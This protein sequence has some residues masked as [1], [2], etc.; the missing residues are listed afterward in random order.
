MKQ[1]EA[2]Y[3]IHELFVAI[4]KT[5]DFVSTAI[6][7]YVAW[8][9]GGEL[10]LQAVLTTILGIIESLLIDKVINIIGFE[11]GKAEIKT[12]LKEDDDLKKYL[13]DMGNV[14]ANGIITAIHGVNHHF[15]FPVCYI[16]T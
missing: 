13:R 4:K 10:T 6:K 9:S 11:Q 2:E 12:F 14:V 5:Y 7:L 1:I 15:Q 8:Y 3:P 16:K